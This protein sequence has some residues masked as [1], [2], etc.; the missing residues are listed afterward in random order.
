LSRYNHIFGRPVRLSFCRAR[1]INEIGL[2]VQNRMQ[3]TKKTKKKKKRKRKKIKKKKN[4][5]KKKK[6]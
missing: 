5:K 3:Q 1:I 6:K 2:K 4:C